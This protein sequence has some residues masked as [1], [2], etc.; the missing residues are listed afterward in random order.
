MPHFSKDKREKNDEIKKKNQEIT[1]EKKNVGVFFPFSG[2]KCPVCIE[3]G[4]FFFHNLF[5]SRRTLSLAELFGQDG[6]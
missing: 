5:V 6:T 1:S 3:H 2:R 4:G